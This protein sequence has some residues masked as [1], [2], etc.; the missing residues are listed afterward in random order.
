[1]K[2]AIVQPNFFPFKAY[3]DLA[4]RV[5]R[6]IFLDDTRYNN[7]S[8]VNKTVINLNSKNY[9]FRVPLDHDPSELVLTK[10][11][12]PKNKSW[13]N[14]FLKLI[15]VQYK[16]SPNFDVLYPIL[17]EIINIPTECFAHM[18][19]YSVFRLAHSVLGAKTHF[20]F[21]SIKYE[22]VKLSYQDKIF[23]IC[24]K[25]KAKTLY[26][27]AGNR[28]SFD[29]RKFTTGGIGISYFNSYSS[30]Y[31]FIDEIMHNHSYRDILEKE[32]NLLQDET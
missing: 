23:H 26:T 10:D 16:R 24:K 20:T 31:S 11:V 21:S 4:G 6:F 28:G 12:R 29:E 30:N 7:K 14:K 15:K 13:K 1:M 17:K 18:S 9:Y 2:I 32:C 22:K 8:W 27:F 3:Y 5:D 25:E 19:A